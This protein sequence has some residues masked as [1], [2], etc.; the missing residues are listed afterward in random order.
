MRDTGKAT[1]TR[2]RTRRAQAE[3]LTAPL[4][5]LLTE[6]Q[7]DAIYAEAHAAGYLSVS[8]YIRRCKLG[9]DDVGETGA[10]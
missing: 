9:L 2:G 10:R 7:R 5:V 1:G 3:R 6:A 8:E 4:S